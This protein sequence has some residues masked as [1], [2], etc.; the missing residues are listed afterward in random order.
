ME[1]STIEPILRTTYAQMDSNG[2]VGCDAVCGALGISE[3][4]ARR[5]FDELAKAGYISAQFSAAGTPF[6]I[7][8]TE[9]G[10]QYCSGWPTLGSASTFMTEF[11]SAIDVRANDAATPEEERGRLKR[12]VEAAGSVGQGLLTDV[13]AKVIE[14]QTGL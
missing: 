3:D 1:W 5:G 13:A 12:F 2:L 8:P 10:L 7:K 11:L 9:K 4:D 14:H 6:I